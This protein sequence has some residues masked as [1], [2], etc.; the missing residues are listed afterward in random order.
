[1]EQVYFPLLLYALGLVPGLFLRRTVPLAFFAWTAFAW[2]AFLWAIASAVVLW[3]PL[4]SSATSIGL[5]LIAPAVLV[6]V[7]L[8]QHVEPLQR[9][10]LR[11][12]ATG[13]IIFV[14]VICAASLLRLVATTP[15]SFYQLILANKWA[16]GTFKDEVLAEFGY[17]GIVLPALHAAAPAFGADFFVTLAPAFGV[18]LLG[19]FRYFCHVG[20]DHLPETSTRLRLAVGLST[21]YLASPFLLVFHFFYIHNNL[22]AA[23]YLLIAVGTLWLA[24]VKSS[25]AHLFLSMTAFLAFGMTRTETALYAIGFL[26]PALSC[27]RFPTR[28]W[29]VSLLPFATYIWNSLLLFY[30]R[31]DTH[32]MNPA[33]LLILIASIFGLFLAAVIAQAPAFRNRITPSLHHIMLVLFALIL[34]IIA[35]VSPLHLPR[36]VYTFLYNLMIPGW[37]WWGAVWWVVVTLVL[38]AVPRSPKMPFE[39]ILTTGIIGFVLL[40]MTVSYAHPFRTSPDDSGNRTFIHLLPVVLFYLALKTAPYLCPD[41]P[42]GMTMSKPSGTADTSALRARELA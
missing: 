13:I 27:R 16:A 6:I 12:A 9:H 38:F 31:P 34:L 3:S 39:R 23:T 42:K 22:L 32:I 28:Y 36:T 11:T 10:E 1:M 24:H 20:L 15:D 14:S 26:I 40:L 30:V 35:L 4:P 25:P 33:R 7:T 18:T 17:W 29:L 37:Q 5:L 2:G 41:Q 8:R 19:S 21:L